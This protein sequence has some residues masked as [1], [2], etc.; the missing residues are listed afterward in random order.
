[1]PDTWCGPD[2]PVATQGVNDVQQEPEGARQVQDQAGHGEGARLEPRPQHQPQCPENKEPEDDRDRARP[3]QRPPRPARIGV[4]DQPGEDE[5]HQ[6]P[7]IGVDVGLQRNADAQRLAPPEP[8]PG[9]DDDAEQEEAQ[10]GDVE[11]PPRADGRRCRFLRPGRGDS[12]Q[13]GN[14]QHRSQ[15]NERAANENQHTIHDG[16]ANEQGQQSGVER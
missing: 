4:N 12:R 6:P 16:D 3:G 15:E 2:G 8:Q 9:A 1:M 7:V 5:G 10:P 13:L 14:E 11:R